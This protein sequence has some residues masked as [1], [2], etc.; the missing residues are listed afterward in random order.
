MANAVLA[1]LQTRH[2]QIKRGGRIFAP[3][4]VHPEH[5]VGFEMEVIEAADDTGV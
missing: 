3:R 2:V 4:L 1:S 5:V